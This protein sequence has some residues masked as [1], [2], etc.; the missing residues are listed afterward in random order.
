[1]GFN[2]LGNQLKSMANPSSAVTL[3]SGQYSV[4]PA[5]QYLIT[6]GLYSVIQYY[7]PVSTTWRNFN[8]AHRTPFP[9]VSDGFNYRIMNLSGCVVGAVVTNGGTSNT[10][11]T[12]FWPAG[13]SSTTG[14]TATVA[15]PA[16]APTLTAQMNV[17][18]GGAVSATVTVAAGGAGYVIPP[19]VQFSAP[20][21]GGVRATGY[22]VLTAGVVSSIVVTNQGAGYT[23]APTVTLVAV[24]NDPGTGAVASAVLVTSTTG[25]L[26][27]ACVITM[28]NYGGGYATVPTITMAGLTSV[29]A[30]AV[31][32][33][34]VVTA[35]TL[36]SAT[37][38]GNIVNQVNFP[39]QKTAATL[40]G[41]MTNPDYTT[42]LFTMR[43]GL[44]AAGTSASLATLAILD[45]GLSQLDVANLPSVTW[46]SDGT[47][48]GAYT[49]AS[50]ASGGAVSDISWVI[51]L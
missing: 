24:P 5:G 39:A 13:S 50:G 11:K 28:A 25:G 16:N 49:S 48:P 7:D 18:V 44:C 21:T 4:L 47:I 12:G 1:M 46:S 9:M 43:N 22:A 42:N 17:I 34:T 30:T 2:V 15:A 3:Q 36:S 14:V 19:I 29:A 20:A 26:G 45:G 38:Y 31:C 6:L 23:T 10:A 51:P 32:C 41:S 33:F 37:H 35:P 27:Q 40:F 8:A